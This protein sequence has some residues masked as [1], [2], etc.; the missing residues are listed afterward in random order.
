MPTSLVAALHKWFS[1][2]LDRVAISLMLGLSLLIGL[3][4]WTGDRTAA[5]V[6]DFSW[7]DKQIGAQDSAFT[8]TFNRPMDQASVQGNLRIEPSLAGKI[9]WAGRRMAYTLTE[10]APYGTTFQVRLE[11][12]RDQ[13]SLT[14]SNRPLVKPFLGRF[15]TRDRALIYLGVEGTDTGR[16]ILYNLT[17][18]E[19][20]ALTPS[21]LMIDQY[22]PYPAG[23]R[24]LFSATSQADQNGLFQEFDPKLYTVSTGLHFN[25]PGQ[26]RHNQDPAGQIKL[27][28]DNT[29]YKNYKFDLSPDGRAIVIERL[30]KQQSAPSSLW[31]LKPDSPPERLDVRPAED[32]TITPDSTALVVDL[33][34]GLTVSPL[35]P[36]TV[37]KP[38]FLPEFGR[39]LSFAWDG[40]AA[41]MVKANSD[42]SLSL[43]QVATQGT[44]KEL[45]RTTGSI[46]SAHFSPDKQTL[47]CLLTQTPSGINYQEEHPYLL[48]IELR[49]GRLKPLAALPKLAAIE[50]ETG[51]LTNSI[52]LSS[53]QDWQISLAPDGASLVYAQ[54]NY[55]SQP[56]G[57][58]ESSS[59]NLRLLPVLPAHKPVGRDPARLQPELLPLS[60]FHPVWLP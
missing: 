2:P 57:R 18:Q 41:A 35:E 3:L 38:V 58:R 39:V 4:L 8:L 36:E 21:G 53:R 17:R 40:S 1:Q 55:A 50:L 7:Q 32:F 44:Q 12:A 42:N 23:D 20:V 52:N 25:S 59:N 5:Q 9:S 27:V 60:G 56:V 22:E 11:G 34:R 31:I 14:E 6:R 26:Q 33:G 48:A 47:Y 49:T 45:L 28:L 29:D 15:T 10:P 54:A 46:Y 43:V 19:K 37:S 51:K 30:S 16:L 13:F 24:I